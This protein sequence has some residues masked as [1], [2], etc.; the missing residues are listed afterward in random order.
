VQSSYHC[1]AITKAPSRSSRLLLWPG[2]VC[3][4]EKKKA[5]RLVSQGFFVTICS[6]SYGKTIVAL[7]GD[8][9][10]GGGGPF[11][12]IVPPSITP[13]PEITRLC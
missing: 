13:L 10:S 7:V 2:P 4:A 12:L 9:E 8:I 1:N 5:P 11:V 3:L 6:A